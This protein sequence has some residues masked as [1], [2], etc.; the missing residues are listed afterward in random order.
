[1]KTVS[2][3]KEG[4]QDRRYAALQK[5]LMN[6]Q[7]IVKGTVVKVAPRSSHARTTYM[8]TRKVGGKTVTVALSR[9]QFLAFRRA[10]SANRRVEDTLA[11]MR[12]ISERKLLET[13]PGV[14]KRTRRQS[15]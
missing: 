11:K 2:A 8:W 12:E 6:V 13:I 9:R 4:R 5:Q 7:L 14:K 3:N 1:M 15:T 10:I